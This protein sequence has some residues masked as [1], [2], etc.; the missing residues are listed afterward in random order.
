M[1]RLAHRMVRNYCLSVSRSN[2]THSTVVAE[3]NQVGVRVT[4]HKSPEPNGTIYVQLLP[5][6]SQT[7]LKMF[8]TS[9]KMKEHVLSGMFCQ[10]ETLCK[11]LLTLQ[12]DHIL[13]AAYL[14]YV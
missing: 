7:L 2:N 11:K 10:I 8:L 9:S 1:M 12:T 6:G 13:V 4:A 5:S 3:L 14:F